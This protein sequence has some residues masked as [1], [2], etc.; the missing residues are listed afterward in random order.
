MN[1]IIDSQAKELIETKGE[2]SFILELMRA[3]GWGGGIEQPVVSLGKP[4]SELSKYIPIEMDGVTMYKDQAFG[5][6]LNFR[7]AMTKFLFMKMLR[8]EPMTT[9]N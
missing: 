1:I 9:N 2:G 5:D 7:V 3:Q 8:L 6:D 4:K